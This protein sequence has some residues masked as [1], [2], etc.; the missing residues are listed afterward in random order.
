MTQSG[1]RRI[2]VSR[3]ASAKCQKKT[4]HRPLDRLIESERGNSGDTTWT[5]DKAAPLMERG[6]SYPIAFLT[7]S[8]V[9][10]AWRKR[11][12]VRAMTAFDTAGVISGVAI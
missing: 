5:L 1:H 3:L 12:P 9:K 10:G 4:F 7:R 8:S 11:L 2:C 6:Y